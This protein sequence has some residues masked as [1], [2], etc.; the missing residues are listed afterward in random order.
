MSIGAERLLG[1]VPGQLPV[2]ELQ[3]PVDHGLGG[4]Q[5]TSPNGG[6]SIPKVPI[7]SGGF[8]FVMPHLPERCRLLARA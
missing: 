4:H 6:S 2:V 5:T 7:S 3:E 1:D 8:S